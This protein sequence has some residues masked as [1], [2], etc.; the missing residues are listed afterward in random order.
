MSGGWSK[1]VSRKEMVARTLARLAYNKQKTDAKLRR[2]A[3]VAKL[4][5]S[6]LIYSEMGRMLGV[7]KGTICRDIQSI[8]RQMLET[9]TK[10]K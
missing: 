1:R 8:R 5:Y 3:K 10:E 9:T 2:R 7:H 4:M 6:G